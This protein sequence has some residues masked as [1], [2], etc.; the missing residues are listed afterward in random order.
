MSA[1]PS[2][3][4]AQE[5][6]AP[7]ALP[8][9][10]STVLRSSR[11]GVAG[12]CLSYTPR[13]RSLYHRHPR[14]HTS[15]AAE[16]QWEDLPS[17]SEPATG[18]GIAC[19]MIPFS[20][21]HHF[22]VSFGHAVM[23]TMSLPAC[24]DSLESILRSNPYPR[25]PHRI[26]CRS[27]V[28]SPP[29]VDAP[30]NRPG[31]FTP[32]QTA[33]PKARCTARATSAPTPSGRPPAATLNVP[34]LNRSISSGPLGKLQWPCSDSNRINSCSRASPIRKRSPAPKP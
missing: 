22:G 19:P 1:L 28:L 31:D 18:F 21:H 10:R 26:L 3:A 30:K 2:R 25:A 24:I 23:M 14:T 4:V 20:V 5:S 9:E 16:G 7:L 8:A 11:R 17:P 33:A 13:N 34:P 12:S 6:V 27:G 29:R 15:V 32:S